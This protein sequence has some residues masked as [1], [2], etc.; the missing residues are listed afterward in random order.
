M[1][2]AVNFEI[3]G[4]LPRR[5]LGIEASAGTGK[6]F[7]LVTLAA[8]YVAEEGLAIGE[9]LVVTFTRAAAAEL[10]DR[11]R[12]R[13]VDFETALGLAQEPDDPLLSYLWT[14]DRKLRLARVRRALTDFDSATITTIHGFAQQVLAT[15]GSSVPT[16]PDAV[17]LED[18]GVTLHQVATDILV[19]EALSGAHPADELPDLDRLVESARLAARN[20]GA[21]LVPSSDPEESTKEAARL[22]ALVDAVG[23]EVAARRRQAG[24][25]SFDDLLVQ[26]R[27]VVEG[28][29]GGAA[30][31]FLRGRFR[32]ALIDEFQDTDPVQWSIFDTVFGAETTR[33]DDAG[34]IL[35]LVGDPK[36]A[37]Y[38]FRG[39]NVHTYLQ[40][41][42][43]QSMG[44][45][46]L[47]VNW[48]SDPQ[49][50]RATEILLDGVTFGDR[51][52]GFQSVSSPDDQSDRRARS[53]DGRSMPALS[54]RLTDGPGVT[55]HKNKP[56]F[57]VVGPGSSAVFAELAVYIRDLL[58]TMEIPD[59]DRVGAHRRLQPDDIAVLLTA[60]SDGPV[61]REALGALGIP[62]VILR[63]DNV[64][65]SMASNHWH[66]LLAAVA[67]PEDPRKARAAALSWFIGW[68]A[69]RLAETSDQQLVALQETLHDWGEH[70][71]ARGA[72]AFI[73]RVRAESAVAA[74]V[75][76]RRD[77]DRD[78]TDLEHIAE[79]LVLS[80]GTHPT[81][82]T[83]LTTF[84][85]LDGGDASG[86]VEADLAARRVESEAQSVHVMT[87]F[88]AKG[89]EFPVVCCPTLW[90]PQGAKA[91][92]KVWWDET[93]AKRVVDVASPLQ[94]G[95]SEDCERRS[96][97]ADAEAVGANLRVLYVA[98][99]RA[100]HHTAVWW[101]PAE[102]AGNT[103]LARVLF[104]RDGSGTIDPEAFERP[105]EALSGE[106]ARGRLAPLVDKGNGTLEVVSV[107]KPAKD[108][109]RWSPAVGTGRADLKVAV[110]NRSLDR[111]RTRWSF[112]ALTATSQD[113]HIGSYHVFDSEGGYDEGGGDSS[114]AATVTSDTDWEV[115]PGNDQPALLLG[116]VPAGSAFG[117]LVH[118]ILERI[119]F[120]ADDLRTEISI[121][122]AGQI[123]W[124][125]VTLD[126]HRLVEG[127]AAALSTPLGPLFGGLALTDIRRADRI[128]EMKFDFT[129]GE[130]GVRASG[131]DVG[132]LILRHLPST[133]PLRGWAARTAA[134]EHSAVLAG[135]LTGSIDLVV[136]IPGPGGR[137][138][139][140]V[141]DYKTNR[142]AQAGVTLVSGH[143]S[144][145]RLPAA[146]AEHHYPLQAL[147][148][149]V[150]LHRY[151]RWRVSGYDASRHLGGVGYLFLRGMSGVKT[152]TTG[153]VPNGLFEWHPPTEL[154]VDLSD[155]LDGRIP[156]ALNGR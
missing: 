36:Q 34:S 154:I 126:E 132:A 152:P 62:A 83:L 142:L 77:G 41:T 95:S 59:L 134:G 76:A 48:R 2:D 99:T 42:H 97:L 155:M 93:L 20:P 138:R 19:A 17:L 90:R 21:V 65:T 146:M 58:E 85:Q 156:P 16:D 71:S 66:R 89:L 115:L 106:A 153:G 45:A 33:G 104:A 18:P 120:N 32:V 39:A 81:P 140:V 110:L 79:L 86:D 100:R 127:L 51:R 118:Q 27:A 15:L 133:D 111:D 69:S 7:A 70:L 82:S 8:R 67:R 24:T 56:Q 1:I 11:L 46:S 54:L 128:D 107:D 94:W 151:L 102:G 75:L 38:G 40:A 122:L 143:Y 10:R 139:F 29:G 148:Y 47:S 113:H 55:R 14:S 43:G 129:L 64:L 80:A 98:L 44:L 117:T 87:A 130:A 121:A 131:A 6:T 68:D 136:R 3:D 23:R 101:L 84:E 78:M 72:A 147:L 112:S 61:V 52:I 26:L 4:P 144:Q 145:E 105:V 53:V 37:I 25:V 114:G 149:V 30:R 150:A 119:D 73:G 141:C 5:R 74:R 103:G 124:G 13:L 63:G 22:R 135:H 50:L 123:S 137:D 92:A 88:V 31:H 109:P 96:E 60:N 116:D 12:S 108:Q 49:V 9:L 91:E 57:A 125:L 28:E 35:I